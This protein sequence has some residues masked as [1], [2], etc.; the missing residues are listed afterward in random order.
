MIMPSDREA[1]DDSN[2]HEKRKSLH[3]N[4]EEYVRKRRHSEEEEELLWY[5]NETLSFSRLNFH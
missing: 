3:F 2:L 5:V 1:N 4:D